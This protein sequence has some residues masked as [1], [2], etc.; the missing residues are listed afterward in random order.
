MIKKILISNTGNRNLKVNGDFITK[1][2]NANDENYFREQTY[3]IWQQIQNNEFQGELKPV[4]IN[5]VIEL[6]KDN[7]EKVILISSDMPNTLRNDQDTIYAGKILC[8]ILKKQYPEIEFINYPVNKSVFIYDELFTFYRSFLLK[9]KHENPDSKIIYCDAGG[10]SQQKF[11][12]KIS[13]EFLFKPDK[14]TVYYVA[15]QEKGKSKLMR[16]ESYEYRKIIDLE[17]AI[18]AIHSGA[19]QFSLDLLGEYYPNKNKFPLSLIQFLELRSRLFISDANKLAKNISQSK[20]APEFIR[21]YFKQIPIGKYD[22]WKGLLDNNH[23][24]LL[25]EI[26][27]MSQWKYSLGIIEQALH[28]FSMFV[29]NYISFVI[30]KQYGYKFD[31]HYESAFIKFNEDVKNNRFTLPEGLRLDRPGLPLLISIA[32]TIDGEIHKALISIIKEINSF[33]SSDKTGID[34]FR[35]KYT[36]KGKGVKKEDFENTTHYVN[37][38]KCYE[39]FGIDFNR[40]YYAEMHQKV[41]ELIRN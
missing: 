40:N 20:K 41:C 39:I 24:F 13:L 17:H 19:Y 8:H 2:F 34:S 14:F 31:T 22:D 3:S 9:L 21:D 12:L 6:E 35:N 10:T 25:S 18:Q 1:I 30:R 26:L 11:A 15:Q 4:I 27:I 33:T 5:E 7:L 28:L 29:E 32:D 23:F 38:K 36:H 16:G 37:M